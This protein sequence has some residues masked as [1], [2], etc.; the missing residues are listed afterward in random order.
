M[1]HHCTTSITPEQCFCRK[2]D[3]LI[4]YYLRVIIALISDKKSALVGIQT[5]MQQL[6]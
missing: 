6:R 2:A 1:L 4:R 3:L 5:I